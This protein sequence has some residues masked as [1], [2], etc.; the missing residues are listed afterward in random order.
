MRLTVKKF[1]FKITT[2]LLCLAAIAT[3]LVAYSTKPASQ[4]RFVAPKLETSDVR[5]AINEGMARALIP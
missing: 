2:T 3:L 4:G 1:P 5:A